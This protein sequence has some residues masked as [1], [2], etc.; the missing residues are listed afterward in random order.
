[1]IQNIKDNVAKYL[2]YKRY[3]E[4]WNSYYIEEFKNA[5]YRFLNALTDR[6]QP[7]RFYTDEFGAII[8]RNGVLNNADL[9]DYWYDKHGNR[10]TGAEYRNLKDSKKKKYSPFLA[11][12]HVAKFLYE[13]G[14]SL[15]N[16]LDNGY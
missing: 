4:G 2:D 13:I 15:V 6:S 12:Q 9:D 10:I 7:N 5:Y 16:A 8:D 11:N 3:N 1:M 14:K